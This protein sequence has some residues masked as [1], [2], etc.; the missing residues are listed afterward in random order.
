MSRRWSGQDARIDGTLDFPK[1]STVWSMPLP[2]AAVQASFT[3][4]WNALVAA[5]GEQAAIQQY[6]TTV[7]PF[8]M[9]AAFGFFAAVVFLPRWFQ[10]V[11]GS[12]ATESGYQI[13]HLLG[14]LIFSAVASGQI[15]ARTGRYKMLIFVALVVMA[16]GL[17]LLRQKES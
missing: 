17:Y 4:T 6:H 13:L 7:A 5:E 9:L 12:S 11:Q 15:V 10:V 1:G 3:S 16:V 14:G 8:C 2:F